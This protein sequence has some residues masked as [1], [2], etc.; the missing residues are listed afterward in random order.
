MLKNDLFCE[1]VILVVFKFFLVVKNL[2]ILIQI[3]PDSPIYY[4]CSACQG[5]FDSVK[6]E[7]ETNAYDMFLSYWRKF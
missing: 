5:S 3:V 2:E 1:M 7:T 4:Y 6:K